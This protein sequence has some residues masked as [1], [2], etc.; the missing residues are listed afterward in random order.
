MNNDER[1]KR[2]ALFFIVSSSERTYIF[3]S[4]RV[5]RWGKVRPARVLSTVQPV[6]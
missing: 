2:Q 5:G 3:V 1:L 4:L 6:A